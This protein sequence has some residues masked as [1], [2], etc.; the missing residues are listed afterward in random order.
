MFVNQK[1]FAYILMIP[2]L[3]LVLHDLFPHNH[4]EELN[5]DKFS[6]VHIQ[7]SHNHHSFFH[8][9]HSDENNSNSIGMENHDHE[10]PIHESH[11]ALEFKIKNIFAAK[12]FVK[13]SKLLVCANYIVNLYNSFYYNSIEYEN[14]F[15]ELSFLRG[16]P[17]C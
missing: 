5:E 1:I 14:V 13:S 8:S 17:V 2:V 4:D 15:L 6:F 7:H 12:H 11:P 10:I 16:P 3:V 9:H